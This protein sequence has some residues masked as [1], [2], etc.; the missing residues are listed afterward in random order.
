MILIHFINGVPL[1]SLF[2]PF[3]TIEQQDENTY[4]I[5]AEKSA[6][7]SNWI[8]LRKQIFNYGLL[9]EKNL[10][11]DM[12]ETHLVDHTVMEKLHELQ[13]D[14]ASKGSEMTIVGLDQHIALSEHPLSARRRG[15]V[16]PTDSAPTPSVVEE[17]AHEPV[18]H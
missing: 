2:K 14:F 10:I 4:L 11:I 1:T 18:A 3:L 8:L 15:V 5:K 16:Q 6:V 17:P 9:Q 7:F 12:S 13:R